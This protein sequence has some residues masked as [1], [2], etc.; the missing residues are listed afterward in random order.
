LLPTFPVLTGPG[1]I[2]STNIDATL[3]GVKAGAR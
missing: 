3:M 1:V 2:D